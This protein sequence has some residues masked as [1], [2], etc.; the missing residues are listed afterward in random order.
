MRLPLIAALG[1]DESTQLH[2]IL[3]WFNYGGLHRSLIPNRGIALPPYGPRL[4]DVLNRGRTGRTIPCLS[5]LCS[6][7]AWY[8]RVTRDPP[9][10]NILLPDLRPSLTH[11]ALASSSLSRYCWCTVSSACGRRD[12]AGSLLDCDGELK[13]LSGPPGIKCYLTLAETMRMDARSRDGRIP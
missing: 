7:D 9:R 6:R 10:C 3:P 12:P 13:R 4:Q 11:G 5:H 1:D 8:L 2:A